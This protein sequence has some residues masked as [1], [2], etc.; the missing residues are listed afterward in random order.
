MNILIVDDEPLARS[1][2]RT[3]LDDG[4]RAVCGVPHQIYEAANASEALTFLE[5][6]WENSQKMPIDVVLLDIHMPGLDGLELAPRIQQMLL[7]PAI[8]FVTAHAK[9]ALNAFDL[10]AVDYLT[11]PVRQARLQQ[12]LDKVSRI[13]PPARLAIHS[14]TA[15][16]CEIFTIQTRDRLESIPLKHVLYCKS[17]HKYITVRTVVRDYLIDDSL[18]NL[19]KR[20]KGHFLRIHR[21]FLVARDVIRA[22]ERHSDAEEGNECWMVRLMGGK[23]ELLPVSRRQLAAVRAAVVGHG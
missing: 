21:S 19:D 23:G 6:P 16:P 12:A 5:M 22:M 17:E 9:H 20:Y 7:P 4:V 2:L 14:D 8:I 1:R 3:L 10:D 13:A 18:S 15:A 11:K